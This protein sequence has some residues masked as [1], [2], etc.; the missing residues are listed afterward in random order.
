MQQLGE[1]RSLESFQRPYKHQ[2]MFNPRLRTSGWRYHLNDH[3]LDFNVKLF[4][5][6][7]K[8]TIEGIIKHDLCHYPLHLT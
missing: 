3:H 2:A 5:E 6:S 7:A 1:E 4:E 8:E